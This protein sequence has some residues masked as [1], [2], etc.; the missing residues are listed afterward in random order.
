MH[1]CA[2]S[3]CNTPYHLPPTEIREQRVLVSLSLINEYVGRCIHTGPLVS[4]G[5]TIQNGN[6]PFPH[7]LKKT[8]I[9]FHL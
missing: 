7:H 5:V 4:P 3:C 9:N 6:P 8:F 2:T 1:Q